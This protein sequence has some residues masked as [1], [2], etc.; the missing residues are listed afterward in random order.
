MARKRQGPSA[1]ELRR[2]ESLPQRFDVWQVEA[3]QV[4]GKVRVGDALVQPWLVVTASA[5]EGT[6]LSFEVLEQAPDAER[7]WEVLARA[8]R[9]PLAGEPHRPTEVRFGNEEWTDALEGPLEDLNVVAGTGAQAEELDELFAQVGGML[10]AGPRQTGLLDMPGV[11]PEAV[12][13]FFDAAAVY[14]ERAPWRKVGER[15]IRVECDRFESG[16]WYAVMMGQAGMTAGLVLYDDLETL[17]RIQQGDLPQEESAAM[18]AALAVVYG[19]ADELTEAD[20]EAARRHR[21]RVAARDAYPSVYRLDPGMNMRPPLAWELELME[22]CLRALPEFAR[23]KT[24]RHGT[25]PVTVPVAGGELTLVL[26][27]AE[28]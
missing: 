23:K 14:Y 5:S 9:K 18:T 12:A 1:A 24:R 13:S 8:L 20:Q 15:A 22:G 17:A 28:E 2:L 25:T 10:S 3:R 7:A 6:V 16:P 19:T 4:E 27:W 26:S 11:T 21:W